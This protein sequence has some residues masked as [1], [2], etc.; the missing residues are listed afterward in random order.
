M[1]ATF[2]TVVG[3]PLLS[4]GDSSSGSSSGSSLEFPENMSDS[5]ESIAPVETAGEIVEEN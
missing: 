2:F 1:E 5:I 4:F 3:V